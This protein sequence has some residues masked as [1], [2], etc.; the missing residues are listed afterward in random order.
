MLLS[1]ATMEDAG[2]G[3]VQLSVGSEMEAYDDQ[4]AATSLQFFCKSR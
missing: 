1:L 4:A 2:V 3:E